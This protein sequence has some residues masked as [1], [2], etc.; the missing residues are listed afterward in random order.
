MDTGVLVVAKSSGGSSRKTHTTVRRS[1]KG[2][3][4]EGQRWMNPGKKAE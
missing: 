4:T 3:E 2:L 1:C